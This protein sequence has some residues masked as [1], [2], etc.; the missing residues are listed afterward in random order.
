MVY[1]PYAPFDAGEH[2]LFAGRGKLPGDEESGS[3]AGRRDGAGRFKL[4]LAIGGN[5]DN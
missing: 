5:D 1:P 4:A 3:K 2:I